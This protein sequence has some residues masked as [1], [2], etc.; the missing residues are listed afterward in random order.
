VDKK[1]PKV[2]KAH[3]RN[4]A[5]PPSADSQQSIKTQKMTLKCPLNAIM[6]RQRRDDYCKRLKDSKKNKG[7]QFF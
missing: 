5:I 3:F 6:A 4:C 7:F 1:K 2:P